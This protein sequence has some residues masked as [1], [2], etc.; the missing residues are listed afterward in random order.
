MSATKHLQQVVALERQW[1]E[2][3]GTLVLAATRTDVP[4]ERYAIK[5]TATTQE[6]AAAL[7]DE[8]QQ[9]YRDAGA[10]VRT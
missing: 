9:V 5:V 7:W 4:S 10:E 1:D 2:R 6:R 3:R 8:W